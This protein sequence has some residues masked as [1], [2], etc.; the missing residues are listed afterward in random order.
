MATCLVF[1]FNLGQEHVSPARSGSGVVRTTV[2]L[3][4]GSR[5]DGYVLAG[6]TSTPAGE[7]ILETVEVRQLLE[8]GADHIQ[9]ST[10]ECG[11][12]PAKVFLS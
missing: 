2:S 9:V 1:S 8:N 12:S 5:L 10:D 4:D 11:K 3:G 7:E 6:T